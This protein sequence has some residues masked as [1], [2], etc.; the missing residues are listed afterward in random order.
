VF[1]KINL[2]LKG[3]RFVS[4]E[5]IQAESQQVLNTLTPADFNESFQKGQ[6]RWHRCVQDQCDYFKGDSGN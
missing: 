4:I 1:P 6:N 2:R 3:W 5:D